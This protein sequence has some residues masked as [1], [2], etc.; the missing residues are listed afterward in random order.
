MNFNRVHRFIRLRNGKTEFLD[1]V[2]NELEG[3][4]DFEMLNNSVPTQIYVDEESSPKEG[5][6]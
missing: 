3:W 5:Q 6:Q 4:K 2:P 1:I